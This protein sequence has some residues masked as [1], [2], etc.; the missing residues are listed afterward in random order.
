MSKK[1]GGAMLTNIEEPA[2]RMA[3]I[4]RLVN[5][6]RETLEKGFVDDQSAIGIHLTSYV[7]RPTL[8]SK[9]GAARRRRVFCPCGLHNPQ[10]AGRN[11]ACPCGL[12]S[13]T[14]GK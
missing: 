8:F 3:E 14:E 6:F 10:A 2:V 5:Y 13:E 4:E 12:H 11:V 1:G 9:E 7:L